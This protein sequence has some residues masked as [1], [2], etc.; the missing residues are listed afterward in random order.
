MKL[1]EEI[2]PL[3]VAL[4]VA[5]VLWLLFAPWGRADRIRLPETRGTECTLVF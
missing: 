1:G 2:D 4:W 5:L 3:S